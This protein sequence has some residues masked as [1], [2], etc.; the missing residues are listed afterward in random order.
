MPALE[1]CRLQDIQSA[2]RTGAHA[3]NILPRPCIQVVPSIQPDVT[4]Q[5][6]TPDPARPFFAATGP[7]TRPG[8]LQLQ[9]T[10]Y[11][12]RTGAQAVIFYPGPAFKWCG[13]NSLTAQT[14]Q[15]PQ[16]PP[17]RFFAA[18][19]PDARP[20]ALLKQAL[21]FGPRTGTPTGFFYPSPALKWC[22]PSCR[23]SQKNN[24]V[25]TTLSF[26][27]CGLSTHAL[28]AVVAPPRFLHGRPLHVGRAYAGKNR[29]CRS[30]HAFA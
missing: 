18:A 30:S 8:A 9:D 2:P 4:V 27:V 17:V 24:N 13:Q 28:P 26:H 19:G 21:H 29:L 20:G 16:I 3:V 11:G 12:P 15:K 23:T 5:T 1:P 10:Q 6:K 22:R 25:P 14:R 7:D